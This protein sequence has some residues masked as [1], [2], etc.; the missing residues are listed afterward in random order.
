MIDFIAD[1]IQNWLEDN[2]KPELY[3]EC[4]KTAEKYKN[5]QKFES[6]TISLF[7]KYLEVRAE[8]FES[9]I[10]KIN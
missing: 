8:S 6:E 3:D 7:T 5:K 9:Q 1:F 4:I 10:S 2:I